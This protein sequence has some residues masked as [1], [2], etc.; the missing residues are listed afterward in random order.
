MIVRKRPQISSI[1]FFFQCY[2][3]FLFLTKKTMKHYITSESVTEGHPDKLCDQ[4]SDAILDACL[5]Q[6]P[7][8]RVACECLA[9][10][11]KVIIA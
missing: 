8:S 5:A 2:G 3:R 11:G 1:L 10:T 4:I 9:T 7:T 6:D